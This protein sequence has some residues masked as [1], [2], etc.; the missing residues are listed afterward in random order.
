VILGGYVTQASASGVLYQSAAFT[1][2]G[3]FSAAVAAVAVLL[4]L[5]VLRVRR[6]QGMIREEQVRAERTQQEAAA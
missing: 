4:G 6:E 1:A 3:L 5:T 2:G